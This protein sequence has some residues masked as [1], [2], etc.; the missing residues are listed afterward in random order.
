MEFPVATE[1]EPV[2]E[3]PVRLAN[4]LSVHRVRR[5]TGISNVGRLA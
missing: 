5:L 2:L 1:C 3:S 4:W